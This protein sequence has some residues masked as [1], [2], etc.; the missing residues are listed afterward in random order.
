VSAELSRGGANRDQDCG[1]RIQE[2]FVKRKGFTLIEL[3]VVVAIIALL[4]SILLPSLSR[5]RELAK[6]AV[7]S[8]NLRGIG[9]GMHIY[10]N[11]NREWFPMHYFNAGEIT[12][13]PP[14]E[15]ELTYVRMLGINYHLRTA[16]AND[17]NP[18]IQPDNSNHPSRSLFLLI[19]GGQQTA[20]QFVCPSSADEEDDMRNRDP[21]LSG[22][23]Q[24]EEEAAR[25]GTNRFDFA[26]YT[27]LSYAYQVPYGRRGRPRET[28]DTRMPISADKGPYFMAASAED[29]AGSGRIPDEISGLE[30]PVGW[31]NQDPTPIIKFSNEE[32]RPYNSRN[33]NTEG[34]NIL[35]VDDHV[36]FERKPIA[37]I[38]HDNI[39]TCIRDS[40]GYT[41]QTK[42]LIGVVG[43]MAYVP[44]TQ[45]DSFLV[46]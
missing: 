37:G 23:A 33:H 36:S 1:Q 2:A 38:H 22:S 20:G 10:A 45:T 46:P 27:T 13:G 5:A 41:N 11:D 40:D 19:I 12:I 3:L 26:S 14:S 30:P 4:I 7:C 6:R 29:P 16:P 18:P 15:C 43:D 24:G 17:P 9:Q 39:Y 32:W 28:L 21:Y 44:L 25:A 8:S 42:S 35:F 34:Q 31:M